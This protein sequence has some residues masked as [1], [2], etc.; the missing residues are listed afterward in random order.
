MALGVGLMALSCKNENFSLYEDIETGIVSATA[1]SHA[2]STYSPV[3]DSL[4]VRFQ[5]QLRM[6]RC[7]VVSSG[8][9]PQLEARLEVSPRL[10]TIRF[11]MNNTCLHVAAE[12]FDVDI[13]ISPVHPDTFQLLIEEVDFS[14]SDAA[15]RQVVLNRRVDVR[16]LPGF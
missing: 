4:R 3:P 10:V 5:R 9:K 13:F 11:D 15:A 8:C 1:Y 14:S 16:T 6:L 7:T 2:D 12:F